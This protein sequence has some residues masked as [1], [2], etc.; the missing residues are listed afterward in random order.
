LVGGARAAG[1]FRAHGL[2]DEYLITV[3]P[4]LLGEGIPLFVDG[5]SSQRL[6]LV[7]T[8]HNDNGAVMVHYSRPEDG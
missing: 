1:A 2:I 6:Q 3:L 5:G 4:I 8:S 7:K